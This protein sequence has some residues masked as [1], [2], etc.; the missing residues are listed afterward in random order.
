MGPELGGW[1]EIKGPLKRL[2]ETGLALC[3]LQ[4]EASFLPLGFLEGVELAKEDLST[5]DQKLGLYPCCVTSRMSLPSLG[6][7]LHSC[8]WEYR[9]PLLS[10]IE[11]SHK[12]FHKPKWRKVRSI[13]KSSQYA[14]SLLQN[15]HVS[16]RLAN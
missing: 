11:H 4:S 6:L 10:K 5:D 7:R 12:T 13:S 9:F 16:T 1:R 15:T 2:W 3:S 8:L 14:T